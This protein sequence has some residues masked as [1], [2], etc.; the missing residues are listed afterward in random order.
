[1]EVAITT[2]ITTERLPL[3]RLLQ[4]VSPLLPVGAYAYSQGLES[5]V[6]HCWI[7]DEASARDWILGLLAHSQCRLD[8]PLLA[9]I[10]RAWEHADSAMVTHWTHQLYASREAFELQ[11][12]DRHLGQALARL[13][14]DLEIAEAVHWRT[15]PRVCFATL[16]ALAAVRWRIPVAAAVSGYLWAWLENQVVAATKLVPL[17]QTTA[18]RILLMAAPVVAMATD[19]ALDLDDAALGANAPGLAWVSARHEHQYSR[20]FRS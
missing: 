17:G 19:T 18:Q 6:E 7:T 5:A 3:L 15:A 10:Y 8:A 20:L 14:S 16:F 12:E 2:P 13:L 11:Q 1:M 9:R 4:L